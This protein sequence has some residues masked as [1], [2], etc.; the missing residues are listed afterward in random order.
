[1]NA[2]KMPAFIYK[3][4]S[5]CG[6]G[7]SPPTTPT[8]YGGL[9]PAPQGETPKTAHFSLFNRSVLLWGG[10]QPANDA[11]D[12]HALWRAKARPTGRDMSS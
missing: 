9:K 2:G 6:A 5:C 12:A 7:F 10:L 3:T 4:A 8:R 1:M 11:N